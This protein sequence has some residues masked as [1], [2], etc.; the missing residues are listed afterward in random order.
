[1]KRAFDRDVAFLQEEVDDCEKQARA[2]TEKANRARH[3]IRLIEGL[4]RDLSTTSRELDNRNRELFHANRDL[5]K[6][7]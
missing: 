5:A 7:I 6:V 3:A 1:M 2:F 4:G